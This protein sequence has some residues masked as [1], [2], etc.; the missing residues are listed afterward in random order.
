MCQRGESLL[1]SIIVHQAPSIDESVHLANH[2]WKKVQVVMF[3]PGLGLASG[4]LGFHDLQAGP[5]PSMMAWLRP[6]M[7]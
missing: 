5:K 7:T 1:K 6:G 2:D 4:G 3:R